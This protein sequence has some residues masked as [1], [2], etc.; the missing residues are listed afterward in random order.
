MAKKFI[1][2]IDDD[3]NEV[4]DKKSKRK[5]AKASR[6]KEQQRQQQGESSGDTMSQVALLCQENNWRKAVQ[7]CRIARAKAEEEGKDSTMFEMVLQKLERSLRRQM[8]AS[9]ISASQAML[10]KENL[11]DVGQQ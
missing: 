9:F 8:A 11:L 4:L 1:S 2:D 3:S 7:V 10:K 5:L 6:T